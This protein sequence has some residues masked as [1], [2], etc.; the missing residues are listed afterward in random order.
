MGSKR[1]CGSATKFSISKKFQC[2]LQ[3]VQHE[4][5]PPAEF[6]SFRRS[7]KNIFPNTRENE[8]GIEEE[9]PYARAY[10]VFNA[11]QIEGL[12]ED[13]YIRPEA[14]RDLGT[15][16]DPELEAFFSRTE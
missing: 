14:P 4:R 7:E 8:L 13:Y 6:H 2:R 12:P 9:L 3:V 15:A 11:D 16:E 5:L 1:T 10:R